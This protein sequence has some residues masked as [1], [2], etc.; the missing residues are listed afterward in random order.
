LSTPT[1][2]TGIDWWGRNATPN[3]LFR[4]ILALCFVG[5]SNAAQTLLGANLPRGRGWFS[6]VV[7]AICLSTVCLHAR[8]MRTRLL[9]EEPARG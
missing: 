4:S 5:F 2:T 9:A 7:L 6:V 3:G 1:T 8:V